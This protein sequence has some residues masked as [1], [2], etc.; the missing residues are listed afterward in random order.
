[1]PAAIAASQQSPWD[2]FLCTLSCFLPVFFMP[3]IFALILLALL[4][5]MAY[6]AMMVAPP[7]STRR[8][9]IDRLLSVAAIGEK[10]VVMDLGCG[11]G[12]LILAAAERS[13]AGKVIGYEISPLQL[14]VSWLR[15]RLSLR[16]EKLELRP[17]DFLKADISEADVV[18][19][20]L[21]PH[22]VKRVGPFLRQRLKPG[23]RIVS[24]MFEL[25]DWSPDHVERPSLQ[26]YP[27]Y[28]YR[29]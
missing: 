24:Y 8:Q 15:I 17:R 13:P 20:F 1:M 14:V 2:V 28:R 9:D 29:V 10:E 6:A 16:R 12:A 27:V 18:L 21:T 7:L 4:L 11:N 25:P 5:P 26:E 19:L 22:G 23:T 3:L